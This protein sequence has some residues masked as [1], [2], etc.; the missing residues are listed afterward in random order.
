MLLWDCANKLCDI[1]SYN[2]VLWNLVRARSIWLGPVCS[3]LS[4]LTM[5]S[6]K[7][8]RIVLFKIFTGTDNH[9]IVQWFLLSY[10]SL[11]LNNVTK[12]HSFQSVDISSVS[13]NAEQCIQAVVQGVY[14]GF[15]SLY[16]NTTWIS[17]FAILQ[18]LDI[19]PNFTCSL[20]LRAV[21]IQYGSTSAG[22]DHLMNSHNVGF[23]GRVSI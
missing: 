2:F 4:Y 23:G 3:S 16:C 10:A 19:C 8:P 20:Y 6:L 22:W 14:V 1:L 7:R 18:E 11:F 15:Y 12:Y 21:G 5:A 13:G 9:I 17:S